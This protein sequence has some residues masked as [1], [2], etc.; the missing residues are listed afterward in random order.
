MDRKLKIMGVYVGLLFFVSILLILITSF[1]YTKIDPSYEVEENR[2]PNAT[3]NESVTKLTETNQNLNAK[4]MELNGKIS[5]LEKKIAEKD[6]IIKKYENEDFK[7]LKTVALLFVDEKY[8]EMKKVFESIKKENLD[9]ESL[10]I[11]NYILEK[12]K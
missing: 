11:Y 9:E 1:S 2:Q 10:K 6:E 5:D 3:L 4:V 7:K 12:I 8:D